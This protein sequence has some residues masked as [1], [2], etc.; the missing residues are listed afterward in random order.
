M[1]IN[2]YGTAISAY[3]IGNSFETV[4][5]M[6]KESYSAAQSAKNTDK[7]DFSSLL[8][9][10]RSMSDIKGEINKAVDSGASSERIETLKQMIQRETYNVSAELVASA[11]FA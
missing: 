6:S 5:E 2:K 8:S 11:I 9:K 3:G 7:A 10:Q 4:K 1:G